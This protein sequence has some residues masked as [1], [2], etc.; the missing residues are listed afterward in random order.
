MTLG[1]DRGPRC[2]CWWSSRWWSTCCAASSTPPTASSQRR[3]DRRRRAGRVQGPRRGAAAADDAGAGQADDRGGRRLRRLARRDPRRR[4]M[5]HDASSWC[6]HDHRGRPDR[7]RAR[8]LPG[9]DDRRAA[10][11][12]QGPRRGD[13]RR[14]R[15]HPEDRAGQRGRE[16]INANLDAGV[17]L[18]EGCSSRRPGCRTRSAWST[19]CTRAPPRRA[20]ATSPRARHQG[21]AHLRGLHPG[22]AD[23]RPA[24]PRG[25]DRGRQPGRA[26]A[27]QP[28]L[29]EPAARAAV[30]RDPPERPAESP[31]SPIIGRTRPCSTSRSESPGVRKRMPAAAT[32]ER[33]PDADSGAV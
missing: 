29:R 5:G 31:R 28:G 14:R 13:R 16:D 25:P 7:P 8:L 4:L 2:C 30:P 3:P 22:D 17:D 23:A 18:L 26:G 1:V 21:A 12:H 33:R 20:S 19:A 27:A 6:S 32:G 24:G 9:L 15:D 10:E 11:D